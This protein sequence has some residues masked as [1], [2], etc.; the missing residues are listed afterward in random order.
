MATAYETGSDYESQA[1]SQ[2]A[3]QQLKHVCIVR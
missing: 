3:F 2:R 1:E